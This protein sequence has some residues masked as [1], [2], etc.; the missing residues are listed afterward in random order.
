MKNISQLSFFLLT[1]V[2]AV[3]VGRCAQN[4]DFETLISQGDFHKAEIIIQNKIATDTTLTAEDKVKLLFEVDRMRRI[5]LDFTKTENEILEYVKIYVPEVIRDNLKK[6]ENSGVLECKM[7]DGK[8]MYFNNAA[9]NIFR[10]DKEAKAIKAKVVA[11]QADTSKIIVEEFP[12]DQYIQEVSG[13][14]VNSHRRF[15]KPVTMKIKYTLAVNPNVVPDGKIIRCWIP[16]PREI[17]SRQTDIKLLSTQ[18]AMYIVADNEL[19]KQRTIYFEKP[20]VKDS[21]TKFSVEYLYNIS[22]VFAAIDPAKVQPTPGTP[23]LLPFVSEL[24][25]HIVFTDELRKISPTIVG[26]ETNPYLKAKKIFAWVYENIPW[27]SAREYSTIRNLSMYAFKNKHGD[28]GIQHLLFITLCRLNGIPAK[29]QSGWEFQ[30][31]N[32]SMH[33]WSEIYI[34]PYGWVPA[35]VTYGLRETDNETLKYFYLGGM[36]SYRLIFN[37][38]ISDNF[39]PAKIFPRSETVDSQRGEVEWEGGNLY[40]DQWDWNMEW[41]VVKK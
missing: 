18:P 4:T 34:E 6:W 26:D 7:I 35:D 33:D 10:I 25:P 38:A 3:L 5:R 14:S 40:F 16:F 31:P 8:K 22:G 39:Y 2:I 41:E 19:T 29:W 27:A 11:T 20:A 23:E 30:P 12:L 28:C 17:P 21:M 9:A 37:D 36:D 24:A 13:A 1:A 32:D 15:V